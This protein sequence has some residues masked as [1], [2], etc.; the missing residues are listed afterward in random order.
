MSRMSASWLA[1]IGVAI[2]LAACTTT[3]DDAIAT[4]RQAVDTNSPA[5][6]PAVA[7]IT[8]TVTAAEVLLLATDG[9]ID[10]DAALS[11]YLDNPLLNRGATVRQALSHTSGIADCATTDL[12]TALRVDPTRSRTAAQALSHPPTVTR[13]EPAHA[14]S[15][16]NYLLLGPLIEKVSGVG[17]AT[18]VQREVLSSNSDARIVAQDAQLP[19]LHWPHRTNP[20]IWCPTD[21]VRRAGDVTGVDRD[22]EHPRCRAI[23]AR[24]LH[25]RGGPAGGSRLP[26]GRYRRHRAPRLSH[27]RIPSAA[28]RR[29]RRPAPWQCSLSRRAMSASSKPQ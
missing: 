6:S 16:S 17:Y 11:T 4:R 26:A 15:M 28:A 29:S 14:I 23:W 22:D 24:H 5:A 2:L 8:N 3:I 25:R 10:L 19:H 20:R 18:A 27:S 1:V 7:E 21:T 13:S 12:M 9:T